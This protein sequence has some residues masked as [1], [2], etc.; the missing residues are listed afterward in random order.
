MFGQAIAV[1]MMK[2][3]LVLRENKTLAIVLSL[4]LSAHDPRASQVNSNAISL[5]PPPVHFLVGQTERYRSVRKTL[6]NPKKTL[7]PK[8]III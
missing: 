4:S 2:K 3:T 1:L 6:K 7:D 5:P 8:R